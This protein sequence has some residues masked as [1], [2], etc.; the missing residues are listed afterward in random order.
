MAYSLYKIDENG[1]KSFICECEDKSDASKKMDEEFFENVRR[2]SSKHNSKETMEIYSSGDNQC[3][4]EYTTNSDG[5][6]H[7]IGWEIG[8]RH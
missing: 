1:V 2:F 7:T 3:I 4:I 8:E 6:R 5:K